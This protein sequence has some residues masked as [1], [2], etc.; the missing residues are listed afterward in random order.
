MKRFADLH[1]CA[2]IGNLDEVRSMVSKSSE[3]GYGLVGI[4]LPTGIGEDRIRQLQMVC[5]NANMDLVTRIDL[6]PRT[7][8]ELLRDLRRFRRR[9][10][11][12]SVLSISKAVARQAAKDRRVDLLSFSVTN[13]RTRFFDYAEAE[14]ASSALSCLEIDIVPLF[15]LAGFQRV[16]LIS[17]LREEAAIARKFNVPIIISSGASNEYLLRGPHD[18]AALASLFD[19]TI[20][21][22]L[23]ALSENPVAVV[24]RNRGK[25]SPDYLA[26]GLRIVKRGK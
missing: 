8:R 7:S 3:L 19:L 16:R 9:F 10:E 25:L 6:I 12:V 4:P 2:P 24:E 17:R 21:F 23:H 5:D 22:S 1:L 14:L 20:P 15:S 11:I 18:C 13:L 26:P